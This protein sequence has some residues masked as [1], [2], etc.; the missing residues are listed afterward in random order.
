MQL[1]A[2]TY[3]GRTTITIGLC[4]LVALLAA[5]S[6][7]VAL[8]Q[9]P[10]WPT[11]PPAPPLP[12]P[13]VVSISD[14]VPVNPPL[15]PGASAALFLPLVPGPVPRI[16][17][18]RGTPFETSDGLR[19]ISQEGTLD[20]TVQLTYE[21]LAIDRAS[22]FGP[23]LQP[24]QAFQLRTFDHRAREFTPSLRRPWVLE[25][26]IP[27]S[28]QGP[29]NPEKLLIARWE[30]DGGWIPLITSYHRTRHVLILRVLQPG[31]Y[32]LLQDSLVALS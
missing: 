20:Q 7:T 21:P 15:V 24:L 13:S 10:P 28:D 5:S 31:R 8:G 25:I 27:D 17:P 12:L 9:A 6:P 30:K 11:P 22:P 26:P 14:I 32:V 1:R 18:L 19:L 29:V 23:H 16:P 2:L 3:K 4:L